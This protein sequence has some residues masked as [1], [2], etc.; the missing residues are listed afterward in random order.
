MYDHIK[1]LII[2]KPDDYCFNSEYRTSSKIMSNNNSI[3]DVVDTK[4]NTKL[5]SNTIQNSNNK[6]Y[7]NLK[8]S[9]NSG[10]KKL[11]VIHLMFLILF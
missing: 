6:F 2:T 5:Y 8:S 7:S 4:E 10:L 11:K 9:N 3:N 1:N